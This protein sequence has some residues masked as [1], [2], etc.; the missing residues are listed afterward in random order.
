MQPLIELSRVS[1]QFSS[2][3]APVVALYELSLKI[4][5]GEHIAIVG[6]SGSGKSTLLH[7]LGLLDQSS[8]GELFFANQAT[9][10]LSARQR[11]M[12]RNRHIGFVYQALNLIPWMSALENVLLPLSYASTPIP[13]EKARQ[14]AQDALVAVNL[15]HR[16]NAR[17]ATLSGGEQ[18]RVAIARAIVTRPSLILADE[19][20]GAL[21]EDHGQQVMQLLFDLA[22]EQHAG[23]IIVT[24]DTELAKRF[25]RQIHLKMGHLIQTVLP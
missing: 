22:Q 13:Q 1:R 20:T 9:G 14:L 12:L 25:S 3:P 18:Q 21:D 7:L 8:T 2:E 23:L 24:H 5:P 19:P 6:H 16:Q 10:T 17:A 11:A 4:F 15:G